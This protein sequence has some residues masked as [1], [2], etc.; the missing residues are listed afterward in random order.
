MRIFLSYAAEP[1]SLAA[2]ERLYIALSHEG[3]HVFFDRSNLPK[4]EAYDRRI[5]EEVRRSDLLVFLISP[6]A[7]E[8][9]AYA[10][11]ELEIYRDRFPDPS[12]RV[13][14]VLIS[15]MT[16]EAL[17]V[18][19]YLRA[20]IIEEPK[21]DLVADVT[22]RI[23]L[24]VASQRRAR[25]KRAL[26]VAALAL[27]VAAV[28]STVFWLRDR[29]PPRKLTALKG[30][31][32]FAGPSQDSRIIHRIGAGG[33]FIFLPEKGSE[34]W[35][36][37]RLA[38]GTNGWVMAQDMSTIAPIAVGR[39]FGFRG[40]FWQL[41]FTSP[42]PE[43][44][45]PNEYGIDA[46]FVDAIGRCRESLD[47]AVYELNNRMVTDAIIEA[48]SQGVAVRVVTD[49]KRLESKDLTLHEL[50]EKGIPV[51]TDGVK[52]S[53][54]HNKFAILDKKIVWTGSWNYT[55]GST[56]KNNENAIALESE[57]I[58]AVY[59]AEFQQMFEAG[60]F[61][62]ARARA[63]GSAGSWAWRPGRPLPY[64]V[65][66][67]F[68]PED[69][70]L[71]ML[72]SALS[73]ARTSIRFMV[74]EFTL[75]ELAQILMERARN[76][77]EV[78]GILE[79]RLARVRPIHTNSAAK[80]LLTN[81]LNNLEIRLDGNPHN[82]HHDAIVI[83]SKLVITGSFNLSRSSMTLNDENLVVIPDAALA[84]K[85]QEEFQRLWAVARKP[86]G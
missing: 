29:Q 62:K 17:P 35:A 70:T 57:E 73:H 53:L 69:D 16:L 24:L 42:Q 2:A 34:N 86:D 4:G 23:S 18:P 45:P 5:R 78:K 3:H 60:N 37:I 27:L 84:A 74:F 44:V 26:Q 7:V 31:S 41:F 65:E 33:E 66:V 83:D 6:G 38:D 75:E 81:D 43:G 47:I 32:V 13:L 11:S 59:A 48:Q 80:T 10:L 82:L 58:A 76:G 8:N 64:G 52:S 61:S 39:G 56:Y 12:T 49:G 79:Q 46:R 21:G 63:A 51:K 19:N 30:L 85:Y 68:G 25:I 9:G 20:V 72:R 36:R 40:S 15:T 1:E 55:D 28:I 77:V 67:Y 22:N 54:M 14:P 71:G 50:E